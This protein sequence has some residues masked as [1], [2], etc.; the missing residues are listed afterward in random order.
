MKSL[1]LSFTFVIALTLS[2]PKESSAQSKF[3]F[4]VRAYFNPCLDY[5]PGE[6]YC[7]A[8]F[9]NSKCTGW[10]MKMQEGYHRLNPRYNDDTEAIWVRNGCVMVAYDNPTPNGRN[11]TLDARIQ[12]ENMYKNL[13]GTEELEEEISS[14]ICQCKSG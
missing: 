7:G 6:G 3:L 9:D 13:D 12:G 11:I 8:L 1:A 5:D 2:C 14:V 4:K 10:E